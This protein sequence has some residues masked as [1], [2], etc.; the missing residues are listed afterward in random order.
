MIEI[1]S[2]GKAPTRIL[3]YRGESAIQSAIL[4]LSSRVRRRRL[5]R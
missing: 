2:I 1:I 3:L 5:N 4:G